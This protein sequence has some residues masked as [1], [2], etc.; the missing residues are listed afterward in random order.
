MGT[1]RQR[2]AARGIA[3]RDFLKA[4]IAGAAG[5]AAGVGSIAPALASDSSGQAAS[6]RVGKSVGNGL[7][8]A[9]P[10]LALPP[11]FTYKTFGA[12]GSAMQD[13]FTTP[14]IHDGMGVFADGS[15]IRIVRNHELGDSNDI[16]HGSVVGIPKYAY[17]K[18]GPGCTTTLVLDDNA[19]LV[20]SYVGANGMD[21]NCGGGA[22]PWGTFLSCEETTIGTSSPRD[23]GHGYV[24]EIDPMSDGTAPVKPLRAMGRFVHEASAVDADTG[25]VYLTEDNNP[26]CFYRFVADTFGDLR[27][28]TLQALR[29]KAQDVYDTVKG[30]TVGEVLPVAWVKIPD[31]DRPG[32]ESDPRTVRA[33]ATE[34]GAA[35]FLSGEGAT[36]VGNSVVFDSSDGGDAELGQIWKYTPTTNMGDLDEEGE[37]ELLYESTDRRVLDG[38]DNLCTSPNDRV[39]IAEDG[40]ENKSFVRG[41]LN[42]GTIVNVAQNLVPMRLSI[43]DAS[44]KLY[45]PSVPNDGF[46]PSDGLGYS[47][48]AGPRFSP[49]GT[50][51]F[52]NIQ[53][54]GI[55]CAITGDWA[56]LGL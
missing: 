3:R 46:S 21:S 6:P 2:S 53:V 47:E 33:I 30:Q 5:M 27:S 9:G 25:V 29:V 44:G 22:T 42:N 55:T 48:F 26:D 4:G 45:D 17:D 14:P 32:A 24:F 15:N 23:K 11:G 36:M 40:K 52:V 18:R 51:L 7:V 50:W 10:E 43:I 28:G 41:L 39:V 13:G 49:D 56:S 54:P 12:F 20:E 37:L 16:T 35:H 19:D 34:R 31:P 8:V 1:R 38:P